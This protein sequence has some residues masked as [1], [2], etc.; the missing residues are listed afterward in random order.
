MM[1]CAYRAA[2][3]N[4]AKYAQPAGASLIPGKRAVSEA[5]ARD[6]A[7]EPVHALRVGHFPRAESEIE[8]GEVAVQVLL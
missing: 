7:H 6:L 2:G 5:T 4:P 8:L 3:G 1:G